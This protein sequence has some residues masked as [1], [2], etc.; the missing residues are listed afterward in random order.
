MNNCEVK[1]V[2]ESCNQQML[3][4]AAESPIRANG[5]EICFDKSPDIF[6]ISRMK[7]SQTE[8]LGFFADGVLKGF[9][10][11]GFFEANV[12]GR[13]E[14]VFTVYNFYILP[15]ARGK[16]FPQLAMREFMSMVRGKANY[17]IGITLK[18]NKPAESYVGRYIGDWMPQTRFID[19][20]VVNSI[21]VAFP[22]KNETGYIVR[23]ATMEDVPQMVELLNGESRQ[24]DF[25]STT[26]EEKFIS[27]LH[28]RKLQIENYFVA[29]DKTGRMKGVCLAWDCSSFRRTKVQHFSPQFYPSLVMYKILG[30]V[31]P[32][33]T[34]P[35]EGENFYELTIT[36]Y[37]VAERSPSIMHALLAEI[38]HRNRNRKY[39]FLTWGSCGSDPLLKAVKGFWHKEVRSHIIFTS[40]DP[41]RYFI[42]TRLPYL[43][44]AFF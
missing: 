24:R 19:D 41:K 13:S 42:E 2:N 39:H 3:S 23:N 31:F 26:N 5:M 15:E 37:A 36:D 34:F 12:R 11:L 14:N 9:G 21:L 35:A 18:G 30:K 7:F 6:A 17:G 43:D 1:P 38:Y 25:A 16:K 22:K 8:H 4:I 28:K 33:A 10:S 32:M 29:T 44:I 40:V 27:N 20:W